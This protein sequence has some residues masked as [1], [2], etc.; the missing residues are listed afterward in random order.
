M[1]VCAGGKFKRIVDDIGG[2]YAGGSRQLLISSKRSSSPKMAIR[3][4]LLILFSRPLDLFEEV[5][6][7]AH[8]QEP[9]ALPKLFGFCVV[10]SH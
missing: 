7:V 2:S 6:R 1:L 9:K 5:A 8:R 4:T 10:S 3:V